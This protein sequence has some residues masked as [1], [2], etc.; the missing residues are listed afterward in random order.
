[1]KFRRVKGQGLTSIDSYATYIHT[2][3]RA[4]DC[5]HRIRDVPGLNLGSELGCPDAVCG[6]YHS[7]QAKS[8][9]LLKLGP[10]PLRAASCPIQY[11]LVILY[12]TEPEFLTAFYS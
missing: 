1:M 11:S 9:M 6:F 5:G 2:R 12:V 4:T 3:A 8:R 10:Q 7:L